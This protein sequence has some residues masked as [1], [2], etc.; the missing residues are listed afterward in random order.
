[1]EEDRQVEVIDECSLHP[2]LDDG[3]GDHLR[4]DDWSNLRASVFV[5]RIV[6]REMKMQIVRKKIV[7]LA[8]NPGKMMDGEVISM[9][10]G[11]ATRGATIMISS[12]TILG[13][14][15]FYFC[16]VFDLLLK[17]MQAARVGKRC[18]FRKRYMQSR[19]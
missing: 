17:P 2:Q 13:E 12:G 9:T 10:R 15:H 7:I 3:D 1:M 19:L 5:V 4:L 18:F 16:A 6:L 11:E 8:M 14:A